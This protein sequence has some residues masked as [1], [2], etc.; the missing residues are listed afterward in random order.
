M[1]N[2]KNKAISRKI[3]I[4][5]TGI[6]LL[7]GA[8]SFAIV[9]PSFLKRVPF[10]TPDAAYQNWEDILRNPQPITFDTYSTGVNETSLSGIVNLEHEN[11][12]GLED[13]V[14]GIP[15]LVGV[16][17]HDEFGAHLIDAG[18]DA[19]YTDNPHGNIKGFIVDSFLAKG[20][21]EPGQHIAA[22]LDR[23]NIQIQTVW[24]THLHPDHTAGIVDLPKDIAFVAGK[25]ERY[26]NFRFIIQT[27]HLAGIDQL[28]EIDLSQGIELPP[29]GKAIDLFGD[30]SFWAIDSSGH[31]KGHIMFFIN[32]VDGQILFTGDAINI[33]LQ[34]EKSIG[35]GTY[36]SDLEKSQEVIEQII[37]FKALHPEVTLVFG[38]D[39]Q[40]F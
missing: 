22:I 34:F 23:E 16:I 31:S 14:I 1:S 7:F 8:V 37:A 20:S 21:Q 18:L 15:V 5:V 39:L 6:I 10:S 29:F 40:T 26:V 11:A 35:S 17:Q 27:E 9:E 33:G 12:R 36:S 3:L 24:L 30:G 19:A 2:N 32:G 13:D 4:V 38:H 28:N 25:G